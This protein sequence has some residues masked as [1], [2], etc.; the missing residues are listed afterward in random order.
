MSVGRAKTIHIRRLKSLPESGIVLQLQEAQP[1]PL[2]ILM[3]QPY[4]QIFSSGGIS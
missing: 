3:I 1:G 4:V 2:F